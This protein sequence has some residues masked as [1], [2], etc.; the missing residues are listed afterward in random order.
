[1]K[2]E[3]QHFHEKSGYHVYNLHIP[4]FLSGLSTAKMKKHLAN[5]VRKEV[6][7]YDVCV[8]KIYNRPHL[9][10]LCPGQHRK[11]LYVMYQ[12][13]IDESYNKIPPQ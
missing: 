1:M 12:H 9:Q 2:T 4:R 7:D 13:M 8:T 3:Y 6:G 11:R 5:I 10:C